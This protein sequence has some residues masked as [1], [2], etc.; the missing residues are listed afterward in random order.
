[1]LQHRRPQSLMQSERGLS[2]KAIYCMHLL[3]FLYEMSTIGKPI[4]TETITVAR[5]GARKTEDY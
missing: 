1:M 5:A 4:E 3:Y 2:Q